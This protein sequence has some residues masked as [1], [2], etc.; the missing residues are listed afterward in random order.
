MYENSKGEP[1]RFT[2]PEFRAMLDSM[3]D[4][5]IGVIPKGFKVSTSGNAPWFERPEVNRGKLDELIATSGTPASDTSAG[6]QSISTNVESSATN[7]SRKRANG[8]TQKRIT[9]GQPGQSSGG[10]E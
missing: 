8:T 10:T 9:A 2:V 7:G 5:K 1:Y 6:K 3:K 4:P